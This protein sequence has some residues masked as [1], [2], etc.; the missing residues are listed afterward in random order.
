MQNCMTCDRAEHV[1]T[2]A[3]HAISYIKTIKSSTA[4]KVFWV[5]EKHLTTNLESA[6]HHP[7]V[8][9]DIAYGEICPCCNGLGKIEMYRHIQRG[10]CFR[11]GGKGHW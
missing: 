7:K 4:A 10:T 6:K 2:T 1:K 5:C 8:Y 11:C 3:T 9:K